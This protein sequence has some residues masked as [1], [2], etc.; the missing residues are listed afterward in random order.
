MR[1]VITSSMDG[2]VLC[3]SLKANSRANKF[4][5]HKGPVYDVAC[6]PSCTL[7]ASAS[8]DTTI[9][10]WNNNASARYSVLKGHSAP[11]KSIEFNSDGKLL[12]SASDDKLIKIWDAENLCFM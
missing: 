4:V 9:R 1:Q 10:V 2:V 12:I 5:G 8:R 7:L 6:N 11:V 3:T